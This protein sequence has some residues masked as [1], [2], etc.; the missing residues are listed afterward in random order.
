VT[1][2]L[3]FA[4]KDRLTATPSGVALRPAEEDASAGANRRVAVSYPFNPTDA[5]W[6]SD[7]F[8]SDLTTLESGLPLD[9]K[10]PERT[11]A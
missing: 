1:F 11:K 3:P 8:K 4:Q 5:K 7:T 6:F 9:W 2:V 10:H